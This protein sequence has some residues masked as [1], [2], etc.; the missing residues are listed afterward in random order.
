MVAGRAGAA[1]A[2]L[3][4]GFIFNFLSPVSTNTFLTCVRFNSQHFYGKL[5]PNE[6]FVFI[7]HLSLYFFFGFICFTL[8]V[9][10]LGQQ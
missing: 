8:F 10:H 1:T 7:L 6:F 4:Y 2:L 9:Q 5:P 3:V